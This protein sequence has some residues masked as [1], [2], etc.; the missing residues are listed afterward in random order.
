[1]T[2]DGKS[3]DTKAKGAQRLVV[4]RAAM[5]NDEE[6]EGAPRKRNGG[7][8][9]ATTEQSRGSAL[10]F[11]FYTFLLYLD[12]NPRRYPPWVNN[13]FNFYDLYD[14]TKDDKKNRGNNEE[15]NNSYLR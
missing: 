2:R 7:E 3:N 9:C 11:I 5:S 8:G 10:V 14:S 4:V 12:T 13:K 1:V 6:A 15:M